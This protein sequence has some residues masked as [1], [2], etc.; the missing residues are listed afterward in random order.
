MVFFQQLILWIANAP[1]RIHDA[2]K[3]LH[4]KAQSG[5]DSVEWILVILAAV[6]IV[7]I[8]VAA[9]TAFVNGKIGGL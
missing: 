6:A 1:A 7:G 9:V 5:A 3:S 4:A 8:I 2:R